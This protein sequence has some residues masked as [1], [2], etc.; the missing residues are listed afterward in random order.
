MRRMDSAPRGQ[1]EDAERSRATLQ[2]KSSL[3][4]GRWDVP[5]SPVLLLT[6]PHSEGLTPPEQKERGE[7]HG[8]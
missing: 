7:E 3:G 2:R 4:V 6:C 8:S 5:N 1:R